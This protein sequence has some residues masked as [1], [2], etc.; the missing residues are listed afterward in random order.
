[1]EFF[2]LIE[3]YKYFCGKHFLRTRRGIKNNNPE[4]CHRAGT[5][6]SYDAKVVIFLVWA[7]IFA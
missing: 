6:G 5:A 4:V 2:L 3:K 1:M 7:M